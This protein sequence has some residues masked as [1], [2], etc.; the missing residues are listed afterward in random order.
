MSP[1]KTVVKIKA[2]TKSASGESQSFQAEVIPNAVYEGRELYLR[3]A[4][5]L[6]LP[7]QDHYRAQTIV[8]GIERFVLRE[9]ESGNR[10]DFGLVSFLPRLSAALPSRDADPGEAGVHLRGAVKARKSLSASL[11]EYLIAE[12]PVAG[13]PIHLRNILDLDDQSNVDVI[14]SGH[15]LNA[16][17]TNITIDPAAPDEG[18]WLETPLK[19][20]NQKRKLIARAE[21]LDGMSDPFYVKF[22]FNE[23]LPHGKFMLVAGT[24]AGKGRAYKLRIARMLVRVIG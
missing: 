13:D 2:R 4:E 3:L 12:N 5:F 11:D 24:R 7:Y 6:N 10:L 15:T 14:V 19:H 1:K 9:L 20:L 23:P 17:V 8:E 18:I 16:A 21:V 22:R